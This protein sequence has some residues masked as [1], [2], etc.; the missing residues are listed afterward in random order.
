M[1]KKKKTKNID[2]STFVQPNNKDQYWHEDLFLFEIDE[3][4]L[5][6]NTTWL[7]SQ[8]I[9]AAAMKMLL[10]TKLQH[11]GC[12][13]HQYSIYYE[14]KRFE[15]KC[16]QYEHEHKHEPL[17]FSSIKPSKHIYAVYFA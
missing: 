2:C 15:N 12:E 14:S 13:S 3:K 7:E 8:H 11:Q 6:D 4:T 17:N 5:M 1:K 10:E 16:L 9:D